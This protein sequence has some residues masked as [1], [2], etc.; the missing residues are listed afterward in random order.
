MSVSF[1]TKCFFFHKFIPLVLEIFRFFEKHAHNL[2][3]LQNNLVGWDLQIGFNLVF[4]GL[5]MLGRNYHL[6]LNDPINA[7][8]A[9][10]YMHLTFM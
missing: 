7:H 8:E 4:K 5:M 1:P 10:Q 9:C 2:N 3:T 6:W